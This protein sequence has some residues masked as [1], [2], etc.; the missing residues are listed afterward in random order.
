MELMEIIEKRRAYKSLAPVEITLELI[1]D[2]AKT[3]QLA[4][5]CFNNQPWRF[6]FIHG[7]ENLENFHPALSK[8]NA[9]ARKASMIVVVFSKPEFDCQ[10][11]R[12]DYY[13]FGAGLGTAFLILRATEL[14]LVAHPMA[15]FNDEITKEVLKI[16][17]DMDLITVIAIGKWNENYKEALEEHQWK[18]EENRPERKDLSEYVYLNTYS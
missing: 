1:E 10:L 11:K 16:P 7:K 14:G 15:G 3:A 8:G 4:P 17:K 13:K 12:G 5:S 6:V 2:L 9:W 18:H